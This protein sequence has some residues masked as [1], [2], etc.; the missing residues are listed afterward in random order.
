MCYDP[1]YLPGNQIIGFF[2]L[3]LDEMDEKSSGFSALK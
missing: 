3:I 2:D 1:K